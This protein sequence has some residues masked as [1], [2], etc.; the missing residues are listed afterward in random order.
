[1]SFITNEFALNK[2]VTGTAENR[3]VGGSTPPL[4]TLQSRC[5]ATTFRHAILPVDH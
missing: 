4:A 3:K 2:I 1:M 5:S